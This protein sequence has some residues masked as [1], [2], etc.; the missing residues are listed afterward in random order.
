MQGYVKE[1]GAVGVDD[2]R[3]WPIDSDAVNFLSQTTSA[4]SV[5]ELMKVSSSSVSCAVI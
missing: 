4:T 5:A 1:D 2:L 3:R